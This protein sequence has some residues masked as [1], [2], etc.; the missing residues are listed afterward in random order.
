MQGSVDDLTIYDLCKQITSFYST[1]LGVTTTLLLFISDHLD[2]C[3]RF[4]LTLS[5]A[6]SSFTVPFFIRVLQNARLDPE[7]SNLTNK[8]YGFHFI[9]LF[10]FH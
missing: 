3:S 9:S 6:H 4:Q 5:S 8:A 7:F 2:M 1:I 10:D